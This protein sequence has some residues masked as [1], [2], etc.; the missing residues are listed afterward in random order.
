MNLNLDDSKK[1]LKLIADPTKWAE[2]FL[3]DPTNPDKPLSLRSYQK[4]VTDNTRTQKYMVLRFGRRMGKTV[5]FAADALWWTNVWPSIK[6][7]NE[8][9]NR[10]SPFRVLI[11]APM[12]EHVK[13][14]FDTIL[15]LCNGSEFMTDAIESVK[16]S[17]GYEI[18]FKNGSRIKGMTIGISSSNKGTSVRGQSAD[19]LF[20]DEGDYIPKDIMEASIMPITS[21]NK[22]CLVRVC[23]TPSGKRELFYQWCWPKN[24]D[25]NTLNGIK[26]I[27]DVE[28]GDYVFG[29][30]GFP[31][32]IITTYKQPFDGELID[33]YTGY[34]EK[35]SCTPNHELYVF[36]KDFIQAKNIKPG[37][38]I[39]VPKERY[40]RTP[41]K[42]DVSKYYFSNELRRLD[43][44]D[45]AQTFKN[46]A[47]AA[48]VLFDS[49]QTRRQL[50]KYRTDKNLYGE[51]WPFDSRKRQHLLEAQTMLDNLEHFNLAK[52]FKFIGYYLAEGNILKAFSTDKKHYYAGLQLTFNS[53]EIEYISEC[54]SLV[55]E[56][57]PKATISVTNARTD[58]STSIFITR[59]SLSYFFIELCGEYSNKKKIHPSILSYSKY[60]KYILE[61]YINGDGWNLDSGMYAM[62]STSKELA[63]QLQSICTLNDIPATFHTKHKHSNHNAVYT[64]YQLVS[65]SHK[66]KRDSNNNLYIKVDKIT[67]STHNDYVYNLETERTHTYNVQTLCSHN[68]TSAEK[69]G[70]WHRHYPTWHPDNPSWIS[71]EQIKAAGKPLHESTEYQWR[72]VMSEDA[73]L[74]EYGA[75]FGD[76]VQGVYKHG[77]I[78]KSLVRYCNDHDLSDTSLFDPGFMQT[79]GNI[80]IIGVDWNTY[81][82]GGQVVVV[83]YC[84]EKT[85]MEYHDTEEGTVITDC[86][87]KFRL[88][89][90]RG[91]KTQDSTQ[92]E[93]RA[94]IIRLMTK[95]RIDHLYVDYGA[96]DT[97]IEEL[98]LYDKQFPGLNIK[99]K[100]HVID[101]GSN[102]EHYD[103]ILRETI[104]KRA[105]SMIVNGSVNFLEQ[106]ILLLPHEE[107]SSQR[108]VSQMRSYSIK[109]TTVRGDFTYTGEDHVLDAFNLAL[110]GF[111]MQYTILLATRYE[112][113]VKFMENLNLARAPFRKMQVT[114]PLKQNKMTV[115]DPEIT[116]RRFELPMKNIRSRALGAGFR[117]TF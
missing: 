54:V 43:I 89:Y 92:R 13:L 16:S 83:E 99:Q 48:K 77:F 12:E 8:G 27:S 87:G 25:I 23:S 41:I 31:E 66:I 84:K 62:C 46:Y 94:E 5:V 3:R 60:T 1:L 72:S 51:N 106:G 14:I 116:Q 19:Y 109:T 10:L 73:Y 86:T 44:W 28:I 52:L 88:F 75:E 59:S 107:D 117:R 104:T 74:R 26:K 2:T 6:M 32:K 90:R 91:V 29:Q 114:N 20:I 11:V 101:A 64:I 105:K 55:K 97:N 70:W 21:T 113:K 111:A 38:F 81:I 79:P 17:N 100:L 36:E 18:K 22:D 108:L 95:W 67:R 68:C 9:A 53:K 112:N 82:N 7:Y 40:T 96:G 69:L 57:F 50:F 47:E 49:K 24:T 103:P 63:R 98:T 34:S 33:I 58:N 39:F 76:E 30:D 65:N 45:K 56:L 35:V 110:H 93:T 71:I 115:E 37:D 15:Q 4:E 61:G 80:Y 78:N 102:I 42:I 85:F